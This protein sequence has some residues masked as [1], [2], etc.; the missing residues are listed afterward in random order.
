M[1]RTTQKQLFALREDWLARNYEYQFCHHTDFNYG[2]LDNIMYITRSGRT[3][4]KTTYN[5][6]IIMCDTETSKKRLKLK[7]QKTKP[8]KRR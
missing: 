1:G 6:C 2:I 5:N 8:K 7:P 3:K 4:K